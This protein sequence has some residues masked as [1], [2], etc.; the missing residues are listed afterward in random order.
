LAKS[1]QS[2]ERK[3]AKITLLQA[4]IG[5]LDQGLFNLAKQKLTNQKQAKLLVEQIE[6]E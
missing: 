1:N 2:K 5:E 4:K 3:K 6:Q